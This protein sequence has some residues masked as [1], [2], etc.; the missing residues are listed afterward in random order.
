VSTGPSNHAD[1]NSLLK[2]CEQPHASSHLDDSQPLG[3]RFAEER[4]SRERRCAVLQVALAA[5]E[6]AFQQELENSAHLLREKVALQ[7]EL[8]ILQDASAAH[9]RVRYLVT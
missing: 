4:V 5:A 6:G 8:A 1:S 3:G 9:V 7:Q 2:S